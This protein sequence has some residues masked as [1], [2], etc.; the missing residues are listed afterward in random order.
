MNEHARFG[1]EFSAG[2]VERSVGIAFDRAMKALFSSKAVGLLLSGKM[3]KAMYASIMQETYHY[4]KE[5][6][7]LQALATVYF[8]G[9][10]RKM[11]SS[12]LKHATSEIGHDQMAID[13]A[14]TLGFDGEK[15]KSANPLPATMAFTSYGFYQ[16]YNRKSV[17]YLGYLYFL[18]HMGTGAGGQFAAGLKAIGIPENAMSF[19]TEHRTADV[20]HNRLMTQYLQQLVHTDADLSEVCYAIRVTGNLYASMLD[21]ACERAENPEAFDFGQDVTEVV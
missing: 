1:Q 17:G 20:G 2:E 19:L 7:Q 4:T 15:M 10:D 8:R 12:F 6:P 16:I 5:D 14:A 18:E 21:Q 9:D 13:D 3:T 11:V